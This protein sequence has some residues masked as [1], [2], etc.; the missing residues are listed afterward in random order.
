MQ[1]AGA[2]WLELGLLI[3]CLAGNVARGLPHLDPPQPLDPSQVKY[4]R[5]V[6]CNRNACV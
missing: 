5:L 6:S 3:A 2:D 1:L 4:L